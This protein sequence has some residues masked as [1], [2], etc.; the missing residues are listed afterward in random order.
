MPLNPD[1]PILALDTSGPLGAVA[2]GVLERE[3]GVGGGEGGHP[4]GRLGTRVLARTFLP[5]PRS[6]S[7]LLLPAI[8]DTLDTAGVERSELAGIVVGEGPGSF[9]GVRVAA[10]TAKG[11]SHGLGIPLRAFSSLAA[12]ALAPDVL[13]TG[14]V[15]DPDDP[16]AAPVPEWRARDA[17]WVLFDARGDR[18]YAAC[19]QL[20][21]RDLRTL[22]EPRAARIGELLEPSEAEHG[23]A[24]ALWMGGGAE[25]HRTRL[26][27][28]GATVLPPPAGR[29][30]GDALLHLLAMAPDTPSPQRPE[31]WEPVYLRESSAERGRE[32]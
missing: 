11:L 30:T 27:G 22:V 8:R 21:G 10:A 19:Y 2:V 13:P 24:A 1:R 31:R 25:R 32:G 6:H 12:G 5:E 16:P 17:R 9:T 28:A 26:E 23:P 29:P 15:V 4:P 3:G 7:S 20:R 14:A 18:V